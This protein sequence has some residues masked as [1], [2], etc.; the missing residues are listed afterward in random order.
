MSHSLRLSRSL[1]R[2]SWA[3]YG[4]A[5]A[6]TGLTLWIRVLL[7]G[8]IEVPNLIALIIP[9]I[10]SAYWGGLRPGVLATIL[11]A[12]G[13]AYYVLPPLHSLV[14]ASSTHRLQLVLLMICGALIS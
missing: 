3:K 6:L 7:G 11:A 1:R 5:I 8:H 12:V 2:S 14:V 9:I 13:A 10:L 4:V